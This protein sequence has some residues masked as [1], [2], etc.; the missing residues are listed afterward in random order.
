LWPSGRAHHGDLDAHAAQPG[1]A[2]RPVSLDRG[3]TLELE[4]EFGE[5]LDGGIEV[6]H[7]DADVVHALDRHDASSASRDDQTTGLAA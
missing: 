2:I 1:D 6:L 5:K 4:T 3:A 7:H